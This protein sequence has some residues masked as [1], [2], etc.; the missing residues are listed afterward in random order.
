MICLITKNRVLL[1]SRTKQTFIKC[2]PCESSFRVNKYSV[3]H[4][5]TKNKKFLETIFKY[6]KNAVLLLGNH[7]LSKTHEL[8]ILFNFVHVLIIHN[9][10]IYDSPKVVLPVIKFSHNNIPEIIHT[11]IDITNYKENIGFIN[12]NEEIDKINSANLTLYRH[13]INGITCDIK[14]NGYYENNIKR[15]IQNYNKIIK[16]LIEKIQ[17]DPYSFLYEYKKIKIKIP[18]KKHNFFIVQKKFY[19]NELIIKELLKFHT[20]K[21]DIRQKLFYLDF[22]ERD[23]IWLTCKNFTTILLLNNHLYWDKIIITNFNHR[24]NRIVLNNASS[25]GNFSDVRE[26]NYSSDFYW[27][28]AISSIDVFIS[29]IDLKNNKYNIRCTS[30]YFFLELNDNIRSN[31]TREYRFMLLSKLKYPV[32]LYV[33]ENKNRFSVF[34]HDFVFKLYEAKSY[35]MSLY[36]LYDIFYYGELPLGLMP[37]LLYAGKDQHTK[38]LWYLLNRLFSKY[39]IGEVFTARICLAIQ[40]INKIVHFFIGEESERFLHFS[41]NVTDLEYKEEHD[42]CK[43]IVKDKNFQLDIEIENKTGQFD[44]NEVQKYHHDT[45]QFIVKSNFIKNK[46]KKIPFTL[47]IVGEFMIFSHDK[48]FYITHLCS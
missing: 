8:F 10:T 11:I 1:L 22:L 26:T 32:R 40:N 4:F 38:N 28:Q 27:N 16:S 44:L 15:Y 30:E 3:F 33:R 34:I 2:K 42:K 21:L 39:R 41:I 23:N 20:I 46:S 18:I 48:I 29:N 7:G 36:A 47:D 17:V 45:V 13:I 43:L 37:L 19:I 25:H 6:R 24:S 12:I 14:N 31:N 35:T 9:Q 5:I